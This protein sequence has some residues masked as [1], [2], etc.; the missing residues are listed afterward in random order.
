[1]NNRLSKHK[2]QRPLFNK[3]LDTII[4]EL[5]VRW[6]DRCVTFEAEECTPNP[7]KSEAKVMNAYDYVRFSN[8]RHKFS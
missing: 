8:S 2:L 1:M 6:P 5:W 7:Y 3:K 4:V